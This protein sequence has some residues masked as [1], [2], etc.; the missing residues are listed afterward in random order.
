MTF[1]G[2]RSATRVLALSGFLLLGA[3]G[4]RPSWTRPLAPLLATAGYSLT[5]L[6]NLPGGSMSAAL[7]V[8]ASGAVTGYAMTASGPRAFIWDAVGGMRDLGTL[9]GD[10]QSYGTGINAS[11][12][13]CG[14]SQ[15][16][17][18]HAFVWTEAGGMQ[19]LHP[20]DSGTNA[21]A[22]GINAGGQVAGTSDYIA[23][24]GHLYYGATVWDADGTIHLVPVLDPYGA[25][26]PAAATAINDAGQATG[27]QGIVD[28]HTSRFQAFVWDLANGLKRLGRPTGT[29]GRPLAINASAQ[30][31]GLTS[32]NSDAFPV[33]WS[34]SGVRTVL[35]SVSTLAA[36]GPFEEELGGINAAG[37]IVCS[38]SGANGGVAALYQTG[39]RGDLDGLVDPAAAVHLYSAAGVNDNRQI[40]GGLVSDDGT[41]SS[42]Y[43]LTPG[44]NN[45]TPVDLRTAANFAILSSTGITTTSGTRIDGSLGVSPIDHTAMT[46]FGL[47]LDG[48]GQFSRSS[49]VT[50]K[51]YA[52]D[53]SDPTPNKLT[54]AI[55]DM[56]GAYNDAAG[57]LNPTAVELGAGN[58]GGKTIT[59]GLYKWSSDV[60]I[61]SNVTLSGPSTGIWIFQIAGTLNLSSGKHVYLTGGALPKNVY[62]QV[63]GQTTIETTAVFQGNILDKTA[64]VIKTGA[65]LN[66]RALAQTAV[67][68][69]A[70]AIKIPQ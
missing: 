58:I 36:S 34:P 41:R 44:P 23:L 53:Y 69:D 29:S 9:D 45:Q 33:S 17:G 68:L 20:L 37:L 62:W 27:Y 50:G 61:P 11:G 66:G 51:I 64:V 8:N 6:G 52:A 2:S 4:A 10:T 35:D 55:G 65:R 16:N 12:Q 39:I 28:H 15:G 46:G 49:L 40:V 67:T 56:I 14:V 42:A 30:V 48:S 19:A 70:N 60:L 38:L 7:A 18:S 25:G 1:S 43:I 21:W 26:I 31:F 3:A 54:T 47:I 22:Y 5:E 13:V 63:A 24:R 59:P 57:R 32:T